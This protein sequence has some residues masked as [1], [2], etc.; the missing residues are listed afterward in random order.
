MKEATDKPDTALAVAK[1]LDWPTYRREYELEHIMY[2][3]IV[4]RHPEIRAAGLTPADVHARAR[5]ERWGRKTHASIDV[6]KIGRIPGRPNTRRQITVGDI[7]ALAGQV[8]SQEALAYRLGV[9]WRTL[10]RRCQESKAVADAVAD[11]IKLAVA[12]TEDV[13]MQMVQAHYGPMV[14][15]VLE[16]KGDY[17]EKTETAL[18]GPEGGPVQHE[19]KVVVAVVAAA[20]VEKYRAAVRNALLREKEAGGIQSTPG[21][22]V[23]EVSGDKKGGKKP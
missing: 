6:P 2:R 11:A 19:V 17:R 21:Y 14:K 1:A 4:K 3:A 16:R 9:C 5:E 18:T 8:L 22:S 20:D 15:F 10:N 23:V 13:A 7:Q 12:V